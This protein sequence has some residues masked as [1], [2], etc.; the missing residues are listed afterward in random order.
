MDTNGYS[1]SDI[2]AVSDNNGMDGFGGGWFG[3][4]VLIALLYGFGGGNG[5]LFGNGSNA[6][7]TDRDVLKTSADTQRDVLE[8]KAESMKMGYESQIQ[9]LKSGYDTNMQIA[10]NR[11]DTLLGFKDQQAQMEQCCCQ[12][13]AE[14]IKENQAT[15]DLINAQWTQQLRDEL[16]NYKNELANTN[17]SD[18]I[19][20]QLD[21][22]VSTLFYA[23][24]ASAFYPV[25]RT[26]TTSA[27][28]A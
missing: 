23:G 14:I 28:G 1:L 18:R 9:T 13:K 26:A 4:L 21:P 24:Q 25:T 27:T 20:N 2:K 8:A 11:F 17:L 22:R 3:F 7:S 15:R 19:I 6:G 5:G 12:L 16:Q 10:Q